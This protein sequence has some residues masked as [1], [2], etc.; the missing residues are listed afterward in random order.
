MVK[1]NSTAQLFTMSV[2]AVFEADN[3]EDAQA[4]AR[5]IT[6]R[7]LEHPGVWEALGNFN[8][9]QNTETVDV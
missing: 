5:R 3:I 7:V 9:E 2:D 4:I 1:P 8:V 6:E